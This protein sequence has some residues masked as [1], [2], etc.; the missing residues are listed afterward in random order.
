MVAERLIAVRRRIAEAAARVGRN[1]DDITLV[2][3]SKG[4]SDAE[5][6]E[7]YAAGQ[8]D[9]GENRAPELATKAPNLPSDI[10]WHFIGSL[11]TRQ[12]KL[13]VP[14]TMLLHSLDRSR[15][16]NTWARFDDPAPV[17]IQVNVAAEAQKHGVA[18]AAAGDL[19]AEVN[20]A[21]L[22]CLGLMTIPPL[23]TRPEDSRE[24]FVA[25]RN[26]Q[27]RL[28]A[29]HRELTH[30]SMGMTDDFEVAVEE[31]ATII[32]V[33]RAIFGALGEPAES[34]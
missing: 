30:L 15:L 13:A 21:G 31:G 20:D 26:L 25:L 3:V 28:R 14:Y 17:L 24:W 4:R 22:V 7:A 1:R 11:Q 27:S 23:G 12:A 19:L 33:G 34:N 32:R 5:I 16:V 8:R 2:A 29:D 10:R 18:P 6:M 9:F